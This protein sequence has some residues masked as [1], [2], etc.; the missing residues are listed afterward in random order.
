MARKRW[1]LLLPCGG[2]LMALCLVFPEIGV[3][4]WVGMTPALVWLFARAREERRPR[5]LR[6]YGAGVLYY[7]PFYLVVYHWFFY[8]YPMEFAGV[9]KA[10]AAVLVLICWLGLSLLQTV[11]SAL[12]F[13]LF[14]WLCQ[15]RLVKV[16]PVLMPFLF[17]AQ[18]TVAEWSQTFT[19]M[20][21]PWARL[22]LG[23]LEHSILLGSASLFGS[24]FITL[25]L[26]A[27][28]G[29]L[30]YAFLH[31]ENDRFCARAAAVLL[32]LALLT[33]VI[34]GAT[35]PENKGEGV[36]VAAV[37]GNIGSSQKWTSE[38]NRK[39]M[40]V[41][42]K[43][44][45]EAAAAGAQI[46]LFPETFLPH[47]FR[48]IESYVT[49]LATT[50]Q[51]TLMFGAFLPEGGEEYNAVFTVY[52]D[53]SVDES[54]Y[55]KRHLVPFGEYVPWRP[56]IEALIPPL[57]DIGMLSSDLAAGEDSELVEMSFGRVGALICF[58]SIYESLV[59]DSVRDGAELLV[60]PTND[61]WFTDSAAAHMHN[62]QARLRAIECG[63]WIL[64]SADTGISAVIS[65]TGQ[66][67]A[68]Q[69]PMVEGVSIATVYPS[70]AR[71]LY[72]RI[73]NFLVYL[74]IAAVLALPCYELWLHRPRKK[75]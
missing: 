2:I 29:L 48:A 56:V 42:E 43:Y 28:N 40:E 71:T 41:Y 57:A 1:L 63:R 75:Q 62:G 65:P 6:A 73:G 51:V 15:T 69:P 34:G 17:A 11:F 12:V 13:P 66:T 18:Y 52:P 70:S 9:T 25:L 5:T 26:V 44:T 32:A 59:L 64:R 49:R 47:T 7:L 23:Q 27:V 60:L 50:Y 68:E 33:G 31:F 58:D 35:L 4:E 45:A 22:A 20:G 46:V 39:T 21:V 30:A 53:G 36:V 10:E 67:Y 38:S 14:F 8:L 54:V 55:R 74:L 3:L 61:S 19:W 16:R 24:Y 37:Q 72:S